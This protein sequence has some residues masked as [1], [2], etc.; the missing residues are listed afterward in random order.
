MK[1]NKNY[2][3]YK[4]YINQSLKRNKKENKLV[5]KNEEDNVEI[6]ESA[7]ELSKRIKGLELENFSKEVENIKESILAGKYKLS[8][9][10]IADKILDHID[11]QKDMDI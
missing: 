4:N 5:K 1:I 10:E 11:R 6:S 7:K 8:S 9:E 2:E 3:I